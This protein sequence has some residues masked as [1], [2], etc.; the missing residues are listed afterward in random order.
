MISCG[1]TDV[2]YVRLGGDGRLTVSFYP[3]VQVRTAISVAY[4]IQVPLVDHKMS[5]LAGNVDH[6]KVICVS[7]LMNGNFL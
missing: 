6:T 1:I 4:T 3:S 7:T 2:E 5:H